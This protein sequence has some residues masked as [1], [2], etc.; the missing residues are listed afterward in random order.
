MAR[1]I[2]TAESRGPSLGAQR[3]AVASGSVDVLA[4]EMIAMAEAEANRIVEVGRSEAESVIAQ[5]KAHAAEL[6][7]SARLEQH[8]AIDASSSTLRRLLGNLRLA[9]EEKQ[10][11]FRE[12]TKGETLGLALAIAE[13]IL[14]K[15][16]EQDPQ[17]ALIA[18]REALQWVGATAK[19]TVRLGT[20]DFENHHDAISDLLDELHPTAD[21]NVVA[22]DSIS[23]GGVRIDTEFGSIDQTIETQ[24]HRVEEELE[25]V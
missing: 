8:E 18:T 24:L 15:H 13:R 19:I 1:I 2:Q 9:I 12:A 11:E 22:D 4:A 6:I 21:T 10:N 25:G 7:Q 20:K 16:V 14:R 17:L 23:D 3:R 5:A